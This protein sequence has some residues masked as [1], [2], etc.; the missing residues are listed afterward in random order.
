MI[1]SNPKTGATRGIDPVLTTAQKIPS[2]C[3]CKVQWKDYKQKA[4]LEIDR[5]YKVVH[6]KKGMMDIKAQDI[7]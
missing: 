2:V 3:L 5:M 4:K 1:G 6:V 7:L